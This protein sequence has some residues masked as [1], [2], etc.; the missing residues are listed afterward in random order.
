[1][2]MRIVLLLLPV[3][4]ETVICYKNG[5]VKEA[6]GDMTPQ[7]GHDPTTKDPPFTITADKSQFSP[8][9]EIKGRNTVLVYLSY[10]KAFQILHCK[11][12][13]YILFFIFT[14]TLSMANSGTKHYFKGFLIEARNAGNLN[15][16]VG[17]FKL[18]NPGISQ[19]LQCDNKVVSDFYWI[20]I[21]TFSY[22]YLLFIDLKW[23][24]LW[25]FVSLSWI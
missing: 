15:E 4:L 20:F 9:D 7:H 13:Q 2:K 18:I 24:N 5:N 8:E 10:V 14:V 21:K 17:S 1:M 3:C 6:C 22:Y 19:L 25:Y 12:V 11:I 16:I 23:L